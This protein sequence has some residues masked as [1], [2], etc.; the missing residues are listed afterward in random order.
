MAVSRGTGCVRAGGARVPATRV[1][2]CAPLSAVHVL[3]LRERLN[4]E[5]APTPPLGVTD[6]ELG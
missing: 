4:V 6:F 2:P 5:A 3:V 1:A